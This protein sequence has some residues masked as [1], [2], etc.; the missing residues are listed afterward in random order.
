MRN[1]PVCNIKILKYFFGIAFFMLIFSACGLNELVYLS[2]IEDGRVVIDPGAN[3]LVF[4][5]NTGNNGLISNNNFLG[6][7]VFYKFYPYDNFTTLVEA[8]RVYFYDRFISS[9]SAITAQGFQPLYRSADNL[10]ALPANPLQRPNRPFLPVSSAG[11]Y[12]YVISFPTGTGSG[13][14]TNI[15]P[16]IPSSNPIPIATPTQYDQPV[17]R[18]FNVN[19]LQNPSLAPANYF[20]LYR[21]LNT[22][23]NNYQKSF[24]PRLNAT[25]TEP[26]SPAINFS[27]Y[28]SSGD[29]DIQRLSGYTAGSPLCVGFC[30]VAYGSENFSPIYSEAVVINAGPRY[31]IYV[32]F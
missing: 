16:G 8:D 1:K 3:G 4:F 26:G 13:T 6:Y 27:Y 28:N 15:L 20:Y 18:I 32:Q 22:T 5:H 30:V 21:I 7:E 14:L 12:S 23:Q 25:Y 19:Y 10:G 17:F 9:E 11:A 29:P 2:P 31:G 24:L